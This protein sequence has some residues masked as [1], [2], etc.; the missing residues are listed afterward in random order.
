MFGLL[1]HFF[2]CQ[3]TKEQANQVTDSYN[4]FEEL[5]DANQLTISCFWKN[6]KGETVQPPGL[7]SKPQLVKRSHK[8]PFDTV[9][10]ANQRFLDQFWALTKGQRFQAPEAVPNASRRFVQSKLDNFIRKT[11]QPPTVADLSP[12][13]EDREPASVDKDRILCGT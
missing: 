7:S 6:T 10:D 8:N 1:F 3:A 4:P 2:G 5:P 12:G 13:H 9:P 11:S